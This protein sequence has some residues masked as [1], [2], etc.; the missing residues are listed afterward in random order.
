MKQWYMKQMVALAAL[1]FTCAL[2][3]QFAH[4]LL[5]VPSAQRASPPLTVTSTAGSPTP[6]AR[7]PSC[8]PGIVASSP[9]LSWFSFFVS[10]FAVLISS[11][12][13]RTSRR[14][15]RSTVE[16]RLVQH[17]GGINDALV[18]YGVKSPFAHQAG[19]SDD[20]H[21]VFTKKAV[22]LLQHINMLI[23]F[24]RHRDILGKRFRRDYEHW[25]RTIVWPW[26]KADTDLL[27]TW[28]IVR[29]KGDWLDD[30][31]VIWLG[32]LFSDDLLSSPGSC[33]SCRASLNWWRRDVR[34][35]MRC[36]K[37]QRGSGAA[38]Q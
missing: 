9:S 25:A 8:P 20:K 1:A 21:E 24:Y 4:A 32:K 34:G 33:I 16:Q 28:D 36:A 6:A 15:A 19:V 35:Q 29:T 13:L 38:G 37:C 14:T 22:I 5:A 3:A 26:I 7:L 12:A 30:E 23:D 18:K 27:K 17:A 11:L 31:S 10:A 2:W